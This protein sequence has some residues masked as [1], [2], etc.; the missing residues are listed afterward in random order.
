MP[1][2]HDRLEWPDEG[3]ELVRRFPERDEL[4]L[5][6]GDQLV[7]RDHQ[8]AVVVHRGRGLDVFGPGRHTLGP[9]NLP[10][11]TRL[12]RL[13][14]NYRG[15]I[16]AAVYFV[17][18]KPYAGVSWASAP[19]RP[20]GDP[21]PAGGVRAA[22]GARIRVLQPLL[23]IN[24]LVALRGART[25]AE[26]VAA[27]GEVVADTFRR[28]VDEGGA[29]QVPAAR[30]E[31]AAG[32]RAHAAE[33]LLRLGVELQEVTVS[34]L[35]LDGPA[36]GAAE[37]AAD[38]GGAPSVWSRQVPRPAAEPGPGFALM[39]PGRVLERF[40]RDDEGP[41]R[42]RERRAVACPACH[43]EVALSSR[44]CQQCGHQMV[45]IN[46]CPA[47]ATDLPAEAR[48]CFLC[49]LRLAAP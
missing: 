1:N 40:R 31:V 48:F 13:P 29:A 38:G 11:L 36:S 39:T 3:S 28:L 2:G 43:A 4:E 32:L 8:A 7:V 35:E 20:D 42:V 5:R 45:P 9:L 19:P 16:A 33:G 15:A 23:F 44:F 49:G 25:P 12:S 41:E 22:G 47:C 6:F 17:T 26:I 27:L 46:R 24:Q 30:P 21:R 14:A 37:R 10:V 18:M 34:D